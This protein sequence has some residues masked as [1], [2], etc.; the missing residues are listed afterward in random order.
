M[1]K[2]GVALI[3]CG[4]MGRSLGKQLMTLEDA[5][6]VG[7]AD[8]SAEAAAR[9][10]E[11][12]GAP[13]FGQAEALLDQPGVDAVLIASPPFE[14]RSL[15]ELAAARGKHVF[16]EKPMAPSTRD[17][18]AMTE[19]ASRAGVTL[20]VGQVLRYYAC[21][22]KTIELVKRGEIGTPW[23]IAITRVGGGWSG[24]PQPW[25]NSLEL[26]GGL[27]MEVNAHEIDFMCQVCGDVERV[28]AEADHFGDD[29][30][31]Y[32][33]LYFVSL[34]FAGGAVG[35]L[36]AST[37]SAVNDISGKVQGSEGSLMYT[38][39]FG[40]GEI[41]YAKRDAQPEVLQVGDIQVEQPV[42]K[43]LRLFVEAVQNGTPPPIP[44]AEGR[45]NVAIAEAAYQSA[46]TGQPV[47]L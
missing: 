15:T 32:P 40:G 22:W 17:C 18:D 35:L 29:P 45:R 36:H 12:F 23:G 42:R 43:E 7:V 39:G 38:N 34:R 44:A 25:R 31:D 1:S 9:A 47:S 5:R 30:S 6:L 28:Y 10:S 21:W 33:N 37:V 14:H 4:G 27:L 26:S 24:W 20:M 13:A 2:L 3:G 8:P 19:A 11:E 41:R 16:V 46:R